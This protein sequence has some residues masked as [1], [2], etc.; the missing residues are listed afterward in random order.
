MG[1]SMKG[2]KFFGVIKFTL[3]LINV[4]YFSIASAFNFFNVRSFWKLSHDTI[5][6]DYYHLQADGVY[7]LFKLKTVSK[8]DSADL[9]KFYKEHNFIHY[10]VS[11]YNST[12]FINLSPN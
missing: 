4:L 5:V 8:P 1:K 9:S 7:S 11:S 12:D 2:F 3:F 10:A 6:I